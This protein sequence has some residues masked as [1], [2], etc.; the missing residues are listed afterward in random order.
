MKEILAV[1]GNTKEE[2]IRSA[3]RV[4]TQLANQIDSLKKKVEKLEKE[5]KNV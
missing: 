4:I 5:K 2:I 1:T 3:N